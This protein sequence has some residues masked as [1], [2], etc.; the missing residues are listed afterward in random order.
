RFF[1]M[2]F[3]SLLQGDNAVESI[4]NQLNRIRTSISHFD[5]VAIIRG[6]GGDIGLSCFNDLM[7][8][9]DIAM[10]PLPVITG[11]GHATNETVAE[12]VAYK[13]A[14]T[15]TELADYLLQKFHNFSVPVQRAEQTLLDRLPRI[16]TDNRARFQDK[17]KYLRSLTANMLS[18]SDG[19]LNASSRSLLHH[20]RFLVS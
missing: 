4:R 9:R 2:L 17:A 6:G 7:L 1:H 11:I 19:Q 5:V 14:I 13:N 8:S 18:R 10:F 3:P 20:T 12:L 15:P 16:L